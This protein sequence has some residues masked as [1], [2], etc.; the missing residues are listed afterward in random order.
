MLK[1]LRN[2]AASRG[3]LAGG[4]LARALAP[5]LPPLERRLAR[6]CDVRRSTSARHSAP[7]ESLAPRREVELRLV[8]VVGQ[9]RERRPQRRGAC[10]VVRIA[11]RLR[12]HHAA[13]GSTVEGAD[14]AHRPRYGSS[15]FP[16]RVR[17]RRPRSPSASSSSA[18]GS[19]RRGSL[20]RRHGAAAPSRGRSA[21]RRRASPRGTRASPPARAQ[22]RGRDRRR[23]MPKH[24][25]P[26]DGA[27][28]LSQAGG[29]VAC[30]SHACAASNIE[31]G[32]PIM[33]FVAKSFPLISQARTE[34]TPRP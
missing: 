14:T 3:T 12:R 28:S 24:A 23:G 32:V 4:I 18:H 7:R 9:P 8:E 21:A 13:D 22:R 19:A 33:A 5:S 11:R 34:R 6:S 2:Q 17:R 30:D 20:F 26:Q 31:V 10:G 29:R 27:C 1:A 25:K 16:R 15:R